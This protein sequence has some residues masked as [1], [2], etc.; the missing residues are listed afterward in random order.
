LGLNA[1][2]RTAPFSLPGR[3]QIM[4]LNHESSRF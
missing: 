4:E 3:G 1:E 2:Q